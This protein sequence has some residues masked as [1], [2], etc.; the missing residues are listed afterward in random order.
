[1]R[2]ALLRIALAFL[3][4]AITTIAIAWTVALAPPKRQWFQV[5][6]PLDHTSSP[7]QLLTIEQ[8]HS[9]GLRWFQASVNG[10]EGN[11]P[12]PAW[13]SLPWAALQHESWRL[14]DR[15]IPLAR[16]Q[17]RAFVSP[18]QSTG[19]WN[20]S[21]G[22]LMDWPLWL[23]SIGRPEG[24]LSYGGRAAGWPFL[25]MRSISTLQTLNDELRWRGSFR[26]LPTTNYPPP[27]TRDP[28]A[29]CIPLFPIPLNFAAST[30][31][32]ASPWLFLFFAPPVLRRQ[33]RRRRGHCIDCGY[34]VQRQY[35]SP[36]PECGA[37][38]PVRKPGP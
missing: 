13:Y 16:R 36:C 38:A 24:Y 30:L 1:M 23:P 5:G 9:G 12:I 21:D 27:R 18:G 8:E 28:Q 3:L 22:D 33:L 6:F 35:S 14:R 7:L 19:G 4:G 10:W 37:S 31:L 32:F 34:D 29:G 15:D 25:T 20:T 26:I 17:L 2:C 11:A